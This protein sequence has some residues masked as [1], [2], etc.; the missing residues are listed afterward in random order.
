M[1]STDIEQTRGV[2]LKS[3]KKKDEK[4]KGYAAIQFKIRKKAE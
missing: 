4:Q 1:F 2:V 3:S